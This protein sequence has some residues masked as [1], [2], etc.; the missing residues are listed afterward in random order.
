MLLILIPTNPISFSNPNWD[1]VVVV[2]QCYVNEV[3]WRIRL[4]NIYN[5]HILMTSGWEPCQVDL[6]LSFYPYFEFKKIKKCIVESISR[7]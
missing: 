5:I 3:I 7:N 4:Q 2:G 6:Q 1:A